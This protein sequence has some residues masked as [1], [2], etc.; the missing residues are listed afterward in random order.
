MLRLK[1]TY[2][3]IMNYLLT[4][5]REIYKSFDG[6]HDE[7][8]FDEVFNAAKEMCEFA[9]IGGDDKLCILIAAAYHD[10][11]R[12]NGDEGH[13][14][15][16]AEMFK[17]DRFMKMWLMPE[18][19]EFIAQT[20]TEHRSC[21]KASSLASL[22]LKDADKKPC[23]NRHRWLERMVRFNVDH[24]GDEGLSVVV[25][26]TKEKIKS[27][28]SKPG[29]AKWNSEIALELY[30]EKPTFDMPSDSELISLAKEYIEELERV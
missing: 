30:G 3:H 4:H 16:S 8:H 21:Y 11:G 14:K 15:S 17:R 5:V 1:T 7:R 23:I 24:H 20:I 13:E 26:K 9:G 27:I 28:I 22:I 10:I 29:K 18:D 12:L 6:A 25:E 2:G 19:I